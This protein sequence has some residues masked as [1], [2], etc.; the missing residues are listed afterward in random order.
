MHSFEIPCLHSG[1]SFAKNN[2]MYTSPEKIKISYST[3]VMKVCLV[4]FE[5]VH[6]SLQRDGHVQTKSLK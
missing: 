5:R 6:I 3:T 4:Y 1:M 2:Q